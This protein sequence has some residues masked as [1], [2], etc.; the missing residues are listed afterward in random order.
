MK[1]SPTNI[2]T[3]A[4]IIANNP[5]ISKERTSINDEKE[6]N[7]G[8]DVKPTLTRINESKISIKNM[9]WIQKRK[10]QT[11]QSKSQH[12]ATKQDLQ[13]E[14]EHLEIERTNLS[15][16]IEFEVVFNLIRNNDSPKQKGSILGIIMAGLI[17][18]GCICC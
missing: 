6:Q 3:E 17:L 8:F 7:T 9:F 2:P 15:E 12:D 5:N 4:K 16:S 18:I 13:P 1:Q 14:T 10:H 11:N